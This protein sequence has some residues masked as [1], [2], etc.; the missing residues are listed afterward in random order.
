MGFSTFASFVNLEKLCCTMRSLFRFSFLVSLTVLTLCFPA[1]AQHTYMPNPAFQDGEKITFTVF[2]N[3]IGIYVNAGTA[4]F[5]TNVERYNNTDAYHVVAE[6]TTNKKYDW[7]FKVRD[8]YESYF[9]TERYRS[10]RFVRRISEGDFKHHEDI[11]FNRQNN[12]AYANK[13]VYKL[14]HNVMDVINAVYYARNIDFNACKP[15]DRIPIDIFLD[16][17]TYNTYIRYVGR[18]VVKTRYGKFRAIK[19]KPMLIKGS[20]FDGG[21]K[22][23]LWVTDDAN[24]IPVRAE[25]PISVGSIKVDLMAYDKIRHPLTS[26]LAKD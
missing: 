19:L 9:D 2:Y 25:S 18:E 7:I 10:L 4:V 23:T 15:G 11:V 6:G 8:R 16:G 21:E 14:S 24:H 1:R 5:S 26:L 3:V 22:M 17:E 20:V 12:T 13:K